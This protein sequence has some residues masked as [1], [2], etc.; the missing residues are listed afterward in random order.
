MN[1]LGATYETLGLARER[2]M[3]KSQTPIIQTLVESVS[4]KHLLDMFTRMT[5]E[6]FS[7]GKLNR[8]LGWIQ[9]AVV[10]QG[11]ATLD[12][13]KEINKRHS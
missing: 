8:W 5:H 6:E 11:F 10:V 3:D 13:M 9:C 7:E 4:Y 2:G 1:V 12:E